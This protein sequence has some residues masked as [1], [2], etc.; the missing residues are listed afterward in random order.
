M[1]TLLALAFVLFAGAAL[2]QGPVAYP[3]ETRT[4]T[5]AQYYAWATAKNQQLRAEWEEKKAKAK[6][7]QPQYLQGTVTDDSTSWS[8]VNNVSQGDTACY[9]YYCP[10]PAFDTNGAARSSQRVRQ[11]QYNN[12]AYVN[13]GP[14]TLVNPYCPPPAVEPPDLRYED[15]GGQVLTVRSK[16]GGGVLH[17]KVL[18]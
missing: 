12:P 9:G 10:R 7:D 1:K 4:M 2:A 18:P 14:L 15:V 11:V 16:D 8:V 17:I 13:P 6:A 5:P 3:P